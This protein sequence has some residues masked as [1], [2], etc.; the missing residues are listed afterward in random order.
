MGLIKDIILVK[1]SI[2]LHSG[3]K[4]NEREECCPNCV[5]NNGVYGLNSVGIAAFSS[6]LSV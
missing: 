2:M 6:I 1:L 3:S 5:T 4:T